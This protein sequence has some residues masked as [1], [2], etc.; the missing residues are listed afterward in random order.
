M[1]ITGDCTLRAGQF[2]GLYPVG[3]ESRLRRSTSCTRTQSPHPAALRPPRR[4]CR[5][6]SGA[7]L[8][9]ICKPDS[10]SAANG[11][12]FHG[13]SNRAGSALYAKRPL[14]PHASRHF[15][16]S[17]GKNAVSA[18]GT[19]RVRQLGR[20]SPRHSLTVQ[21]NA[22]SKTS[23][24]WR[25]PRPQSSS[26]CCAASVITQPA[27]TLRALLNSWRKHP[28]ACRLRWSLRVGVFTDTTK[29]S[30]AADRN[31]RAPT[32]WQC[33]DTPNGPPSQTKSS[34]RSSNSPNGKQRG[35][36]LLVC[37]LQGPLAPR[38]VGDSVNRQVGDLPH[39]SPK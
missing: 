37:R 1:P 18:V 35:A 11:T 34:R 16:A 10:I 12:R 22:G 3:L 27:W 26:R 15:A 13:L 31:V 8:S 19:G 28:I 14:P 17:V 4:F 24:V 33:P 6:G 25:L 5:Q 23:A 20:L 36:D 2:A 7:G 21:S 29:W 30:L 9:L 38:G 39:S 32:W